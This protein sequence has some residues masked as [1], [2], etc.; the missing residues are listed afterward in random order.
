MALDPPAGKYLKATNL[1]TDGGSIILLWNTGLQPAREIFDR[2]VPVLSECVPTFAKYKTPD[3]LS[4]ELQIFA[5][6][7]ISSGL[8]V[9]AGE[10][11][12][13]NDLNWPIEDYL[14]LLTTYSPFIALGNEARANLLAQM[15]SILAQECSERIDLSYL[16]IYQV[17]RKRSTEH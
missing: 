7:A 12:E 5:D 13:I 8:F 3:I 17:L 9:S 15:R 2:L 11:R 1:L 6:E 4:Q 16:S 10:G 14:Q